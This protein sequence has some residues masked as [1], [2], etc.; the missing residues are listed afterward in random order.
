VCVC[1]ACVRARHA[2]YAWGYP[3]HP[4]V[5]VM[6][7]ISC[8][9]LLPPCPLPP[10]P[11]PPP[12]PP[13]PPLL[14]PPAAL[15]P[16]E[17]KWYLRRQSLRNRDFHDDNAIIAI[18]AR[19]HPLTRGSREKEKKRQKEKKEKEKR[20]KRKRNNERKGEG[21]EVRCGLIWNRFGS[22]L[23]LKSKFIRHLS[24]YR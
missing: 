5:M 12:P 1:G 19:H 6:R 11:P 10:F 8:P 16:P 20:E 4:D 9:V 17:V 14:P 2:S 15:R 7:S 24:V 13:P 3:D 21:E 22:R 18:M 23:C